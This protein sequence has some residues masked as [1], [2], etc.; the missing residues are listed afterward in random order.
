MQGKH[1]G[2][3]TPLPSRARSSGMVPPLYGRIW[4]KQL[5]VHQYRRA[6]C[7]EVSDSLLSL[8]QPGG[9]ASTPGRVQEFGHREGLSTGALSTGSSCASDVRAPARGEVDTVSWPWYFFPHV[10]S[11]VE[12]HNGKGLGTGVYVRSKDKDSTLNLLIIWFFYLLQL[13]SFP[14]LRQLLKQRVCIGYCIPLCLY[15]PAGI[16]G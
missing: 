5:S 16:L 4:S 10:V 7:R 8:S 13:T 3:K 2:G 6:S 11:A 12:S 15:Y 9:A 14:H 1:L